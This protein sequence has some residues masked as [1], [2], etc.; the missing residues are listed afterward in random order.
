MNEPLKRK[1]HKILGTELQDDGKIHSISEEGTG[2]WFLRKDLVSAVEWLKEQIKD[3]ALCNDEDDRKSIKE[4]L[5]KLI[6]EAF[7]DLCPSGDLI[8]KTI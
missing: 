1:N 7:P 6:N 8:A 3:S 4:Y 5:K 2:H